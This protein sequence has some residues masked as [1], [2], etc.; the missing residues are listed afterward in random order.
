MAVCYCSIGIWSQ[1]I[2][3]YSNIFF[4]SMTAFRVGSSRHITALYTGPSTIHPFL[5]IRGRTGQFNVYDLPRMA[6]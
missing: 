4:S 2:L 3:I 5:S 6:M 1:Q